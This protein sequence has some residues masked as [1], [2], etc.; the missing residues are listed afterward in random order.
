[1]MWLTGLR[2]RDAPTPLRAS[3]VELLAQRVV[4]HDDRRV[5]AE[6]VERE[7]IGAFE[8]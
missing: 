5:R 6:R 2:T 7:Q 1:M 3:S 8:R 4:Q